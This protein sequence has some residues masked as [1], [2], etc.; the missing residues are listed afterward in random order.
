MQCEWEANCLVALWGGMVHKVL[1]LLSMCVLIAVITCSKAQPY[2]HS[3]Q[4]FTI[5][6]ACVGYIQESETN[7]SNVCFSSVYETKLS[8][9]WLLCCMST[10]MLRTTHRIVRRFE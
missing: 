4:Y 1:H 5:V 9:I 8:T 3:I 10:G 2:C 6:N 7:N